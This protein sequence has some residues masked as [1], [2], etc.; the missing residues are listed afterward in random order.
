LI[1]KTLKAG[2]HVFVEKP[3]AISAGATQRYRKTITYCESRITRCWLQSQILPA[4]SKSSRHS[5]LAT[6]ALHAHYRVNAGFIPANH[7][8]QDPAIGGGRIIGEACHFIDVLT[9]LVG[10]P[11]V[12]VTAHALPNN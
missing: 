8:T 3:L 4:R 1:V 11:P 7:W 5:S 6:E 12:A 9:F 10:A 2:K